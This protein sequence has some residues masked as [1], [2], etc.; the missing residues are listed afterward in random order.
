MH[1]VYTIEYI[2][3]ENSCA[4]L[5]IKRIARKNFVTEPPSGEM[6]LRRSA[7]EMRKESL[8]KRQ[9]G[10]KRGKESVAGAT[11]GNRSNKE[12]KIQDK[13]NLKTTFC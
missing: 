2:D 8:E 13:K 9:M 6:F 11:R 4:Y 7:Q 5:E 1:I 10:H 12:W 3:M